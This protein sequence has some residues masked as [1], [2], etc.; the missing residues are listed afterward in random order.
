MSS[1]MRRRNGLMASWVMRMLL[2][3]VRLSQPSI[4]RQDASSRYPVG[5]SAAA[6]CHRSRPGHGSAHPDLRR[7][8]ERARL[9]ERAHHPG[10]YAPRAAAFK[11]DD[12]PPARLSKLVSLLAQ[13]TDDLTEAVPLIEALLGAELRLPYYLGILADLYRR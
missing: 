1:I 10:E 13:G 5:R 7:G 11:R 3:R 8:D 2:S 9:R 4:S 12:P 6:H